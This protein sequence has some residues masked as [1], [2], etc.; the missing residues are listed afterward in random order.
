MIMIP[1]LYVGEERYKY[2][3][4]HILSLGSGS[5]IMGYCARDADKRTV[6]KE[7]EEHIKVEQKMMRQIESEAKKTEDEA[8]ELLLQHFAED[9][10]KHHKILETILN[11]AYKTEL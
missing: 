2:D 10:K 11:K 5:R 3:V 7:L 9:E 4:C 8:L 6:K 1:I